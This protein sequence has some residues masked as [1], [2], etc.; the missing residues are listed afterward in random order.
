MKTMRRVLS[1]IL[2]VVGMAVRLEAAEGDKFIGFNLSFKG[3]TPQELVQAMREAAAGPYA[4]PE[5][6]FPIN[7][8]VPKE[9]EDVKV[10]ALTLRT[11]TP[12]AVFNALNALW[13][14]EG[15]QWVSKEGTILTHR[16]F[17]SG[18]MAPN[19]R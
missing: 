15:L 16:T 11:V 13:I 17:H 5:N 9:L 19:V 8:L 6:V 1:S 10:P 4:E 18:L 12:Q 2:I 14:N 7:A 3:G